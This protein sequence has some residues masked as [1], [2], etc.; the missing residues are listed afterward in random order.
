MED[1]VDEH[2]EMRIIDEFVST[3]SSSNSAED[4]PG[5]YAK[6]S[7]FLDPILDLPRGSDSKLV[8]E[9]KK[10][11]C[12]VKDNLQALNYKLICE[13]EKRAELQH[14]KDSLSSELEELTSNLFEEANGMVANEAKERFKLERLVAKLTKEL[15]TC[16]IRLKE[17]SEQLKELKEKLNQQD[18][19]ALS[20]HPKSSFASKAMVFRDLMR[21]S[22]YSGLDWE[23][24]LGN[25]NIDLYDEFIGYSDL[26]C[27]D[28]KATNS[29]Y[30]NHP[31]MKRCL[32]EDIESCLNFKLKTKG[33]VRKVIIDALM[34][35]NCTIEEEKEGSE[36]G[37]D[38]L[39]SLKAAMT[40]SASLPEYFGSSVSPTRNKTNCSLCSN[41]LITP[42]SSMYKCCFNVSGS[43]LDVEPSLIIDK[44]CRDRLVAVADFF[45][46]I[47]HLKAGHYTKR[48]KMDLFLE[49]LQLR[50]QMFYYKVGGTTFYI[51]N[52]MDVLRE[53]S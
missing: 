38:S 8:H 3:G 22:G 2:A 18:D 27:D 31:F 13:M 17:E 4:F 39:E 46:F 1:N 41:S 20:R 16:K 42:V 43:F 53:A 29:Y 35:N 52:D 12:E 19:S 24:I 21:L 51:F 50:R 30:Y 36:K 34:N 25:I 10:E 48:S 28:K 6:S 45:A 44:L 7:P 26:L 47:R 37:E 15:E 11:L 9:L 14:Q 49:M 5:L 40:S 33:Y 32:E 23:V